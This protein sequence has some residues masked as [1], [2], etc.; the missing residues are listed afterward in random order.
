MADDRQ[1]QPQVVAG[2]IIEA[3][4]N[5]KMLGTR[6]SDAER[7]NDVAETLAWHIS[8]ASRILRP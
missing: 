3:M 6:G 2:K 8:K 5:A 7:G 1:D 4:I